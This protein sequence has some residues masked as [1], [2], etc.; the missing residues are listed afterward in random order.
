M[1]CWVTL[2]LDT[3]TQVSWLWVA[4][5]F[6]VMTAGELYVFPIGL[7]LF[8]RVAPATFTATAIAVWYLAGF[9]GNL[10]GGAAGTLWAQL[11]HPEFF[12]IMGVIAAVAAALFLCCARFMR[13]PAR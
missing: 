10:L 13:L 11:S 9:A 5:F 6:A 7:A 1:L 12:A 2:T 8:A 4:L 3:T